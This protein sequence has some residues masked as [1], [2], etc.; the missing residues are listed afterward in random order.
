MYIKFFNYKQT[1][2]N[3]AQLTL[4]LSVRSQVLSKTGI[5]FMA[6][7]RSERSNPPIAKGLCLSA[8]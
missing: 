3:Q 6:S 5:A 8:G 4:S 7:E 2:K 1:N